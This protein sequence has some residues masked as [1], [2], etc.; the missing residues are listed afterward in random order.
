[1]DPQIRR[2]RLGDVAENPVMT[3]DERRR[4]KIRALVDSAPPRTIYRALRDP[5]TGKVWRKTS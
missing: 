4:A 3:R 5:K 2:A 1:M